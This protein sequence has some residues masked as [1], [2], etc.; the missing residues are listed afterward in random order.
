MK[1]IN[2]IISICFLLTTL[3]SCSSFFPSSGPARV[4]IQGADKSSNQAIQV[5][6]VNSSLTQN[7]LNNQKKKLFSEIFK[8]N[9]TKDYN[10]KPG[11]VLEVNIWEAD[12]PL[13]FNSSYNPLTAGGVGSNKTTLPEQIVNSEGFISIPF[14]GKIS[15]TNKNIS[16]IEE[17]ILQT[18]KSKANQPQ[19]LV[20]LIK[21]LTSQ[22]TVVS[23]TNSALIPLS[24]KGE[25]ILDVIAAV[26]GIKSSANKVTVQLNREDIVQSISLE[27]IIKDS[28]Q[29]IKLEPGD[30]LTIFY[31]PNS[32]TVLGAA[33]KNDEISFEGQGINLVQALARIGGINDSRG[34]VKGLFIFR[35]EDPEILDAK[36]KTKI[37][38]PDGKAAIIYQVNMSDPATFFVSQN[39][40]IKN[41]DVLYVS[42]SPATE[43]Q[44]FLNIVLSIT[45][46]IFN[47]D[48]LGIIDVK[49]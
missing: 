16:Q 39:F 26:G 27:Q 20:R 13:L 28:K 31:Q 12:P 48:R 1:K 43:L 6:E 34:D 8:E 23:E 25:K 29:N 36:Y 19:V 14:A 35:F 7:I 41:K 22:I 32:F 49:N 2:L 37:L 9:K 45:T 4:S 5:I 11:D 21:N 30:V 38:T 33:V 3:S 47:L 17:E 24:P 15:T 46:P 18:L 10:I 44:K 42:N 40:Q